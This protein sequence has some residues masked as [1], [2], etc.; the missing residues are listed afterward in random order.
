MER[1]VVLDDAMTMPEQEA[2]HIKARKVYMTVKIADGWIASDQTGS[3]T[4]VSIRRNKRNS[5]SPAAS[6]LIYIGWITKRQQT[7]C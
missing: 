1:D 2:G 6:N 5:T 3:F 7:F 4:R